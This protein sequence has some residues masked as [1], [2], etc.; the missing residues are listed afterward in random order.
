MRAE[1]LSTALLAAGLAVPAAARPQPADAEHVIL[2]IVVDGPWERNAEIL[3]LFRREILQLTASEF[4]ALVPPEK[5]IEADWTLAGVQR[6]LDR[7]LADPDVDLLIALGT[8][9]SHLAVHVPDPPKPILAPAVIDPAL[10]GVPR[11]DGTSGVANLNYL[12]IPRTFDGDVRTFLEI[13]PFRRLT[14]LISRPLAEAIPGLSEATAAA[15]ADLDL[16]IRLVGVGTNAE[17]ALTALPGDTEAVYVLPLFHMPSPEFGGLVQGLIER[18][19]PSFARLGEK[20]VERGI[21]ATRTPDEFFLRMARRVA[22]HVQ[23]VLLGEEPGSLPTSFSAGERLILNMATA[24]AIGVFPPWEVMTEAELLQDDVR[25]A[26]RRLTLTE[27]VREAVEVNRDLAAE[28]RGVAAG[29]KEVDLS[30][31]RLL[32]QAEVSAL[33]TL[34]DADRAEASFGAQAE[35]QVSGSATVSQL[36]FSE[37]AW[38]DLTIQRARQRIREHERD[39]LELDIALEAATAYLNVLRTKT[40]ERIQKENLRVTRSNLELARV[41]REVGTSGPGEVYRWESQVANDRRAVIDASASR[42]LAEI[43][44][45]RLLHRPLEEPFAPVETDL[46]DPELITSE[47][48]LSPYIDNL[49]DFRLFRHFMAREA[50][51]ASPELRALDAGIAAQRRALTSARRSWWS[52]T[53]ALQ[54]RVTDVFERGGAGSEPLSVGVPT[55]GDELL[56]EVND[57]SWSVGLSVSLP[58]FVGGARAARNARAS[59]ELERLRLERAAAAERV[60]GRIRTALHLMGASRASIGLSRDAAEAARRNL[61]VVSDAYARGVVSV[62]DLLDAQNA[63][64]VAELVAAN[65]EYDFLVDL[66][67]VQRAVGRF[68]FFAAPGEREAYFGRLEAFFEANRE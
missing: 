38:A 19:I 35:R 33:G 1:L 31:S 57:V 53:L 2:G 47:E 10:Q 15:G 12:A 68:D 49:G 48:R 8:L 23:S 56:P 14:I 20:E 52:P 4:G 25:P 21:L 40:L 67:G 34:I 22:V 50:A 45:N 17:E 3:A 66:M 63:A 30:R 43:E 37:T 26:A 5:V 24:R 65:A 32:P 11:S 28:E 42:N 29:E 16:Q 59:R 41:R 46:R 58:L 9:A 62:I 51:D 7:L 36:L 64:L 54:A 6:A 61:D 39:R 13:V 60:E 27:A 55:P 18:G 44:L